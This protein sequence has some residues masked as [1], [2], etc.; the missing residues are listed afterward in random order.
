MKAEVH[1][2][3]FTGSIAADISDRIAANKGNYIS[4]IGEYFGIDKE[5]FKVVGISMSGI[6]SF[7]LTLICVDN[8]KSSPLKEHIVK[9]NV[10]LDVEGQK[11]MLELLFKRINVMLFDAG[12]NHYPSLECDEEVAYE[13]FHQVEHYDIY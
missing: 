6:T 3:D 7:N 12:E 4:S 2:N 1:Y 5:R 10:S 9:M 8:E 11:T 13:D